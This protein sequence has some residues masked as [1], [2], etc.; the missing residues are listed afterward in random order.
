MAAAHSGIQCVQIAPNLYPEKAPSD[1][2]KTHHFILQASIDF[3]AEY[4]SI[5]QAL[6]V[7]KQIFSRVHQAVSRQDADCVGQFER[8]TS[9]YLKVNKSGST[10][11]PLIGLFFCHV[12]S[13]PDSPVSRQTQ[14]PLLSNTIMIRKLFDG[15]VVSPC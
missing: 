6:L 8:S 5:F 9:Y 7:V 3:F 15:A 2:P 14:P 11:H 4:Q 10:R 12:L 13:P 1:R